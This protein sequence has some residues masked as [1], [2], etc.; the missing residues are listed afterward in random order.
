MQG[1]SFALLGDQ[2]LGWEVVSDLYDSVS[3]K[4][5][6]R[7]NGRCP[8]CSDC[9]HLFCN[10]KRLVVALGVAWVSGQDS[11]NSLGSLSYAGSGL[12]GDTAAPTQGRTP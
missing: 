5:L 3:G 2:Q 8:W 6:A 4:R 9:R 12:L 1:G 7:G 11:S 10:R